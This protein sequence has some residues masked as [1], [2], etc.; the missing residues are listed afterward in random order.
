MFCGAKETKW[1]DRVNEGELG[2]GIEKKTSYNSF[3]FISILFFTALSVIWFI[4]LFT[5]D[6]K[7]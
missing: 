5:T 1:D 7:I 6:N 4:K 3:N 2:V